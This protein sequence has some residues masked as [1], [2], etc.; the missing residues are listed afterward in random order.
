MRAT[1]QADNFLPPEA[2][3]IFVL[4]A[5]TTSTAYDLWTVAMGGSTQEKTNC[6]ADYYVTLQA[7]GDDIVYFYSSNGS[8]TVSSTANTSV[9]AAMAYVANGGYKLFDQTEQSRRIR[10]GKHRYLYIVT[11]SATSNTYVRGHISSE[12]SDGVDNA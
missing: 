8:L 11:V 7:D 10:R 12:R 2:G 4:A 1:D 9:G 6:K 3:R 5:N